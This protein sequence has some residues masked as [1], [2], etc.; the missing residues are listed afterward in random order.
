M[1]AIAGSA[2]YRFARYELQPDERRLLGDGVEVPLRPLAFDVLSVL[3][4]RAGHLVTKDELLQRVWGKVIVE[5]NTLQAQISAL[6]KV[7]GADAIATV[8]GQGYRFVPDVEPSPAAA[9][10]A[11]A[12]KHN[13]PQQLTRFIGREKEIARVKQWLSCTRLLTLTGAGGCGKTRLALQVASTLLDEHPDGVWLVELAPLADPT[14]IAQAVAKALAVETQPGKELAETVVEWLGS[15]RLLLVLDNAE[16]LLEACARLADLLLRRCARLVILVTSRERLGMEGELTYRVPSLEVPDGKPED[17]LASEAARLFVDRARLQRPDFDVRGQDAVALVS[18]CRRLDGIALAIEL[19]AARVRAM[20]LHEL[21]QRLDDRFG[22]LTGGSRTALPR[23]RTLRS[24]IDWSHELL[25]VPEK[26]LLRRASVFAGG[27]T[28]EAVERV[29]ADD[30]AD[31]GIDQG[32]V[33]DL[34]TSLTDKSLV[35]AETR[36]SETVFRLLETVRQYALEQLQ[37]SGEE[38]PVRD[39]HLAYFL[40]MAAGLDP[41][42]DEPD[43]LA[44]MAWFDHEHDNARAALAWCVAAPARVPSGLRL[45]GLLNLFWQVRGHYAEGRDWIARLLAAEPEGQRGEAHAMALHTSGALAS[46][47][48]DGEVAVVLHREA[49]AIWRALGN[50]GQLV[51][52]I[53]SLGDVEQ[54]RGEL[55]AAR[56]L[57]AEALSLGREVGDRRIISLALISLAGVARR[58]GEYGAAQAM[59]EECLPVSRGIGSWNMATVLLDLGQVRLARGD[60][61]GARTALSE[62]LQTYRT[63]GDRSGVAWTLMYLAEVSQDMQDIPAARAQIRE[64]WDTFPAGQRMPEWLDVLA[65]LAKDLAGPSCAA[66]VWGCV[67]RHREEMCLPRGDAS[68]HLR[69]LAAARRALNDEAAFDRAWAEGRAWTLDEG[70][71]YALGL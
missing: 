56:D 67:Q 3:V 15:R 58:S 55:K 49:I 39:R 20:S 46:Y 13:L 5:E 4:E 68:R 7:L 24:L 2:R 45:A 63:F 70:V 9:E 60:L 69:L 36:G 12:P 47:D 51:R 25:T 18:I 33:L 42:H 61:E 54:N 17:V 57:F 29:C 62:A 37:V 35:V 64:S 23:H 59:L 30:G 53:G 41:V 43:L 8:S 44:S 65:G 34:L 52:S 50:R 19:A 32:D 21:S 1:T 27:W 14:R 71:R 40:Q 48:G 28:L 10:R 16:H 11:P 31:G 6:R 66:R 22:V 26:V 38:A